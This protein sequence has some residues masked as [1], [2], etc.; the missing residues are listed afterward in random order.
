MDYLTG[1]AVLNFN[2]ATNNPGVDNDSESTT[3]NDRAIGADGEVLRRA[4]RSVDLGI[5][6]PSGIVVILPASGDAALL[7]GCGGGLCTEDPGIG[8]TYYPIYWRNY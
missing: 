3:G 4:D 2:N 8:G 1:E 7:I 6:I 5:G